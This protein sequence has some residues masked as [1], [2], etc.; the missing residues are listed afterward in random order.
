MLI[1]KKKKYHFANEFSKKQMQPPVSLSYLGAA[2][3]DTEVVVV[4]DLDEAS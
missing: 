3:A 2:V 4:G 1:L